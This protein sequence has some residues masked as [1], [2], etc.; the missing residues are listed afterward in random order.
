VPGQNIFIACLVGRNFAIECLC[1]KHETLS[2]GHDSCS[3]S[4]YMFVWC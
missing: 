2:W 3:S 4:T 1:M